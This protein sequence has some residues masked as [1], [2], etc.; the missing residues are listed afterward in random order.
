MIGMCSISPGMPF[1]LAETATVDFSKD[2]IFSPKKILLEMWILTGQTKLKKITFFFF[3]KLWHHLSEVHGACQQGPS[4]GPGFHPGSMEL[5]PKKRAGFLVKN[6]WKFCVT[7]K[8]Q[9]NCELT[10][11]MI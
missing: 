4:Q 2:F 9:G 6:G 1:F 3:H 5:N 11:T 8:K 7:K 10:V